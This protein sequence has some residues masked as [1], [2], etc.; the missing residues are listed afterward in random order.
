MLRKQKIYLVNQ[1]EELIKLIAKF[2][3]YFVFEH[4]PADLNRLSSMQITDSTDLVPMKGRILKGENEG[5]AGIGLTLLNSSGKIIQRSKTDKSG[6]F[7]FEKLSPE[8]NYTIKFEENDPLLNS[9]KK[10]YLA[11]EADKAVKVIDIAKRGNSF[12]NLPPNLM[13]LVELKDAFLTPAPKDSVTIITHKTA[14]YPGDENFDFVVYFPY[15]KKEINISIGSFVSLM[16]KVAKAINDKGSATVVI[17]ASSS[18]V[19]TKSFSSNEALAESRA[20]E[21]KDK[22]RASLSLKNLDESKLHYE[23]NAK[24][25]GPEY[26]NDAIQNRKEYE[27]WQFVKVIVK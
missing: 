12:K 2:G 4:L 11:N 8:N 20:N 10:A 22:V 14:M 24:V 16:D 1:R 17:A 9:L 26:K 18:S 27:K 5:I 19:P 6:M 25:L 3:D 7:R 15:N 23:I 13:Q 21:I